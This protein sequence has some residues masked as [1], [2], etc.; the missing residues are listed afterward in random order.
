[1]V[2][3]KVALRHFLDKELVTTVHHANC[4]QKLASGTVAAVEQ[5]AVP[6]GGRA[7]ACSS[8]SLHQLYL[9]YQIAR[10]GVAPARQRLSVEHRWAPARA[11]RRQFVDTE[12]SWLLVPLL[13]EWVEG[14]ALRWTVVFAE[15]SL[16]ASELDAL[17][18]ARKNSSRC[19]VR[20]EVVVL[21]A[22][23][24]PDFVDEALADVLAHEEK[25]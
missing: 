4:P 11:H 8:V 21:A 2:R 9:R 24:N 19:Q 13:R 18:R 1:M 15:V 23:L 25:P 22:S 10:L 20:G 17:T 5:R 7:A 6:P 3:F 14:A 12:V 16:N